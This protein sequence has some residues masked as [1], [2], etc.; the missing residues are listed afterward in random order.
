M[1]KKKSEIL[2]YW[3]KKYAPKP[4]SAENGPECLKLTKMLKN[5]IIFVEFFIPKSVSDYLKQLDFAAVR[6]KISAKTQNGWNRPQMLKIDQKAQKQHTNLQM[7]FMTKA[8]YLEPNCFLKI[9]LDFWD[10]NFETL[11]LM[12]HKLREMSTKP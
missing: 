8:Q 10:L 5:N 3:N 4:E 7:L 11:T 2:F 1:A 6:E 12:V 9:P